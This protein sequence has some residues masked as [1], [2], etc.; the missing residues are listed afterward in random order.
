MMIRPPWPVK[1]K[2]CPHNE[3]GLVS[4]EKE[5]T[6]ITGRG[7]QQR[8][9]QLFFIKAHDDH[10]YRPKREGVKEVQQVSCAAK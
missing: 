3:T 4:F 1:E 2:Q 7:T 6:I 8:L 5:T 9:Q 10:W